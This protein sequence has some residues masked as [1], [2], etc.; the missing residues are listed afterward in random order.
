MNSRKRVIHYAMGALTATVLL[1]N[2]FTLFVLYNNQF[3]SEKNQLTSLVTLNKNLIQSIST[4]Q[5]NKVQQLEGAGAKQKTLETVIEALRS[6]P[7]IGHTGE[8][9]LAEMY[10]GKIRFIKTQRHDD[11]NKIFSEFIEKDANTAGPMQLALAGKSGTVISQDYMGKEVLAAYTYLQE[12]KLGLVAKKDISEI[13]IPFYRIGGL[14]SIMSLIMIFVGGLVIVKKFSQVV[15]DLEKEKM[16]ARKLLQETVNLKKALDAHCLISITDTKGNITYTND[17]FCEISGYTNE[18]LIGKNHRLLKSD[19]HDEEF[20][21][22]LWSTI[23]SG[24]V[25]HGTIKNLKKNRESYWVRATIY[26]FKDESGKISEYIAVRTD[27]SS[28]KNLEKMSTML[29]DRALAAARAKDDFL[30]N[31]SHEIRTPMN[32]IIGSLNLVLNTSLDA[33]QK[34]LLSLS[35]NAAN[36]LLHIINDVLD[37]VKIDSGKIDIEKIPMDYNKC[38]QE[39]IQLEEKTANA[40]GL[41]L[42]FD[43]PDSLPVVK[44]DPIRLR[45]VL[46]NLLSNAIKFTEKG[47]VK[48][49]VRFKELESGYIEM[50]TEIKDTGIGINEKSLSKI[51]ERFSQADNTTTR[52]YGGT[53]LGI[54]ISKKLIQLMGGKMK[55]QS[56][57]G[58]GSAFSFIMPMEVS[59]APPAVN[60]EENQSILKRYDDT[61]LLAEDNAI[62]RKVAIKTL[63]KMGLKVLVAKNGEEAVEMAMSN[64]HSLLLMD[65][66]MPVMDGI[67]ATKSLHA[68]GYAKPI[69]ALTANVLKENIET[70]TKLGMKGCIAKPFNT[71][72]LTVVLDTYLSSVTA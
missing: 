8:F 29:K 40:K 43:C 64:N 60:E 48:I 54:S 50:E 45:Q 31:M 7:G 66:Q 9:V 21:K 24:E 30:A 49:M 58:E 17:K 68:K 2:A 4:S 14:V 22:D 62:N 61:V 38:I 57:P 1:I 3:E 25:W 11:P 28:Q 10:E 56:K 23:S 39:I 59:S 46:L 16:E 6:F 15:D 37:Y 36:S 19:E 32:G 67:E 52:K 44:G 12:Y 53:G 27:I 72:D 5:K 63:E 41:D 51:F 71:K 47:W 34:D 20:Y 35:Y 33:E 65:I 42:F 13:K 55:V 70:Y 18:E 69:V 26:P